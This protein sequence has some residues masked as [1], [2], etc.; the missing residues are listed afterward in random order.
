MKKLSEEAKARKLHIKVNNG[1]LA[2]LGIMSL[3]SEAKVPD[4]VPTMAGLIKNYDGQPIAP[5]DENDVDHTHTQRKGASLSG[6]S[7]ERFSRKEEVT[8]GA[9]YGS[10]CPTHMGL[11]VR[12]N[13]IEKMYLQNSE[14]EKTDTKPV[15]ASCPEDRGEVPL[16]LGRDIKQPVDDNSQPVLEEQVEPVLGGREADATSCRKG[17]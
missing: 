8:D 16:T 3:A 5:S 6:Q 4:A 14:Q 15:E 11:H 17:D 12:M 13:S 2:M 10:P 9:G 1:S 7:M